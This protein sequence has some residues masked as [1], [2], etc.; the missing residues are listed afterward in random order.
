MD[1]RVGNKGRD[2]GFERHRL[3]SSIIEHQSHFDSALA[4][5]HHDG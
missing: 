1:N 4:M 3:S 2:S 5:G